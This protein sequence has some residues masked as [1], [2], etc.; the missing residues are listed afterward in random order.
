MH[1][2]LYWFFGWTLQQQDGNVA[3]PSA[4]CNVAKGDTRYWPHVGKSAGYY[5]STQ[6]SWTRLKRSLETYV[7]SGKELRNVVI[8]F[9]LA[10]LPKWSIVNKTSLRCF[11]M[12]S[13]LQQ[14]EHST[15]ITLSSLLFPHI[16]FQPTPKNVGLY[17]PD[18]MPLPE[19]RMLFICVMNLV[20]VILPYFALN[21]FNLYPT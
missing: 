7:V 5:W 17:S 1:G 12:V 9:K 14:D 15:F 10:K 6:Y 18:Y 8:I 4:C 11:M 21:G 3:H 19:Q 2:W 20:D 13:L 16:I